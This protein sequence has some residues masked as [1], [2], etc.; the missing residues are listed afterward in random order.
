MKIIAVY[1]DDLIL[2]VK[3]LDETQQRKEGLSNTL[4]MKDME[5]LRYCLGIN[6][7][8]TE[9]GISLCQKQYLLKLLE[10]YRLSEA[11]T[12]S[13]PMDLN[14]KLVI[15]ILTARKLMLLNISLWLAVYYMQLELHA[16]I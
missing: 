10:K 16:Q 5:Q 3:T 12:V 14:V 1:V 11:N 13:T 4:K 2:M 8:L 15:M 6:C 7:E 9:Q